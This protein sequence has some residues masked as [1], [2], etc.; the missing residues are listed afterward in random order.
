SNE[1]ER[2]VGER[3]HLLQA[4][5]LVEQGQPRIDVPQGLEAGKRGERHMA[6][7]DG[8]E[9]IEIRLWHEMIEDVDYHVQPARANAD[10]PLVPSAIVPGAIVPRRS[11]RTAHRASSAAASILAPQNILRSSRA[12]GRLA[13]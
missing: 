9:A 5:E 11:R 10:V 13:S 1:L 12:R 2:R 8:A 7:N 4:V 3:E 6:G